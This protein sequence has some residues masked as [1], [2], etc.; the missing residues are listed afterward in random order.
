VSFNYMNEHSENMFIWAPTAD[1]AWNHFSPRHD[2]DVRLVRTKPH[3]T[4]TMVALRELA[5]PTWRRTW[6]TPRG[7]LT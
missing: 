4:S 3:L 1:E 6:G 2:I 5:R 7:L